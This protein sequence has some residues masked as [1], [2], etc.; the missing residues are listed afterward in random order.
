MFLYEEEQVEEH[1]D[2]KL[3]TKRDEVAIEAKNEA[4]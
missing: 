1:I 4:A 2:L 3:E